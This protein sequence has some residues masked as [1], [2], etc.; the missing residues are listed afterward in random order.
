M[1]SKGVRRVI[2][3]TGAQG[4]EVYQNAANFEARLTS[5][6]EGKS[7]TELSNAASALLKDL[8]AEK[9]FPYGK[10]SFQRKIE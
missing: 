4:V 5:T 8:D 2:C 7:G 6:L 1:E 9:N 10:I 3:V